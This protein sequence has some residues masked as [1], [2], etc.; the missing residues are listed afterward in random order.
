M[1]SVSAYTVVYRPDK[2]MLAYPG[3]LTFIDRGIVPRG[4]EY[5]GLRLSF[6]THSGCLS[7][8]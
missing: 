3:I 2:L 4:Y 8:G 7:T 6:S 5:L 1:C